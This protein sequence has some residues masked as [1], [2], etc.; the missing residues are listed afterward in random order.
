[1]KSLESESR[2][3][4]VGAAEEKAMSDVASREP[5]RKKKKGKDPAD[6]REHAPVKGDPDKDGKAGR[7]EASVQVTEDEQRVR[8][9]TVSGVYTAIT[10]NDATAQFDA[11]IRVHEH[12]RQIGKPFAQGSA[13]NLYV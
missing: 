1:M 7:R 13:D 9:I 6:A 2:S 12:I 4:W 10:S 5:E 3:L 8:T 11:E